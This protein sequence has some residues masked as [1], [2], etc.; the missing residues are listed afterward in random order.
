MILREYR[1]EDCPALLRLFHD[2]VHAVNARDYT[3]PQL[4]AW[5]PLS[6]DEENWDESFRRHFTVVAAVTETDG[7]P[8]DRTAVNGGLK[9]GAAESGIIVGFGDIDSSGY[10]DRLYVHKDHQGKHIGTAVCDILEAQAAKT[11][12]KITVHSSLT[13]RGF[14]EKRGYM[15]IRK[16]QVTRCGVSL[17]NFVMEKPLK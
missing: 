2:T 3:K 13:A 16:Q 15:I 8:I 5:A 1:K 14:F 9:T 7:S 11:S 4:N 6:L 12:K 17:T 10:L